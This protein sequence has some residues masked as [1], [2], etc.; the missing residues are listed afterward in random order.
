LEVLR[1][2]LS[3]SMALEF[4]DDYYRGNLLGVLDFV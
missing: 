3:L 1:V 2:S 4:S